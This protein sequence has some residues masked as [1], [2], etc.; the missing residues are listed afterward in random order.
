[1]VTVAVIG[2]TSS[3]L[4]CNSVAHAAEE[5][6]DLLAHSNTHV[7]TCGVRSGAVGILLDSLQGGTAPR[8]A[9]VLRG[10]EEE[11]QH[12]AAGPITLVNTVE[13]RKLL[14]M[15]Q[16]SEIIALPG[17]LGTHD[18]IFS[19]LMLMKRTPRSLALLNVDGYFDP[20]LSQL[21]NMVRVGFASPKLLNCIRSY[22][23]PG[24]IDG[25]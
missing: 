1:M 14:F 6:G 3:S 21:S 17:G 11:N 22:S 19:F 9:I 16:T 25:L 7:L 20:L 12:H 8:S 10:I 2:G 18:E 13:E 5:L 4:S 15:A 23:T 24:Q